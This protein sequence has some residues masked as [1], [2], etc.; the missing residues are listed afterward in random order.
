MKVF[1]AT[2]LQG[3]YYE[4]VFIA[5]KLKSVIISEGSNNSIVYGEYACLHRQDSQISIAH[6][7]KCFSALC[8]DKNFT[9]YQD[10]LSELKNPTNRPEFYEIARNILITRRKA[11]ITMI[12]IM[13]S[14][15]NKT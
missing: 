15:I 12:R 2:D 8:E 13:T 11:L 9:D 14:A 10:F 6:F 7:E 3:K 5:G 4:F 1:K